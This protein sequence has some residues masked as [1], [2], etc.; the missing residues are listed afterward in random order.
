MILPESF[1]FGSAIGLGWGIL[2]SVILA[3]IIYL[4]IQPYTRPSDPFR[5]PE[6]APKQTLRRGIGELR[7]V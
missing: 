6:R 1:W 4:K 2:I 5:M 3:I 7:A